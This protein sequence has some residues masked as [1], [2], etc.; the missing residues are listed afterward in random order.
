MKVLRFLT[1]QKWLNCRWI[2]RKHEAFEETGRT[3]KNERGLID[4][5]SCNLLIVIYTVPSNPVLRHVDGIV[6]VVL[7]AF[8]GYTI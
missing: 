6:K 3:E 1:W 5:G 4:F 7:S 2:N 8:K